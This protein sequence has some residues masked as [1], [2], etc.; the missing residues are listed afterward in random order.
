MEDQEEEEKCPRCKFNKAATPHICPFD[1][2]INPDQ[3]ERKCK[4]CRA[5][6][7]EC[8]MDI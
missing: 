1:E 8:A 2:E 3:I 6:T 5:C 4:C 7:H